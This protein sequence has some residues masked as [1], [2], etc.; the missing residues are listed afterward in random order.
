[1]VLGRSPSGLAD[2]TSSV[3]VIH[4]QQCIIFFGQLSDSV[5][6]GNKTVHAEHTIGSDE[7]R[8]AILGFAQHLLQ[9]FHIA[10]WIA[11]PLCFTQPYAVD[12]GG[13]VQ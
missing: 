6:P 10:V 5:Q 4:H 8:T 11:F 2:K 9:R 12:N 1:M 13:V 3:T 7:A